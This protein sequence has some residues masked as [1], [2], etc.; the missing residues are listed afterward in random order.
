[1]D[2]RELKIQSDSIDV[3]IDKV[4]LLSKIRSSD[5]ML[6]DDG[7]TAVFIGQCLVSI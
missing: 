5:K 3:A 4:F 7:C 1:M 6:G 2:V